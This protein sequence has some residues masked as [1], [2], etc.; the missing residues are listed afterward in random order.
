VNDGEE[1]SESDDRCY[2]RSRKHIFDQ[3]DAGYFDGSQDCD[4]D[5]NFEE[6]PLQLVRYLLRCHPRVTVEAVEVPLAPVAAGPA[7]F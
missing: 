7:S 6:K 1:K 5:G 2:D 3:Q 4:D